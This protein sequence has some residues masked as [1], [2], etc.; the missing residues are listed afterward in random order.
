M[1]LKYILNN[2]NP[3]AFY[4][5]LGMSLFGIMVSRITNPNQFFNEI[6]AYGGI[7]VWVGI[8]IE[9]VVST[10]FIGSVFNLVHLLLKKL[11]SKEK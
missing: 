4:L 3:K 7:I 11:L 9:I 8:L 2:F 5:A 10:L 1:L 6:A